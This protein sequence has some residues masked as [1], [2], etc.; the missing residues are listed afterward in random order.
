MKTLEEIIADLANKIRRGHPSD[1][2]KHC[3]EAC[4]AAEQ[5]GIERAAKVV[6][7]CDCDGYEHSCARDVRALAQGGQ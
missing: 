5:R 4:I 6:E 7:N 3:A 1:I 2:T